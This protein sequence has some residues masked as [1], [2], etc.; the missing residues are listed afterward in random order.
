M[1]QPENSYTEFYFLEVFVGDNDALYDPYFHFCC[2]LALET[3]AKGSSIKP[4][5]DQRRLET[6]N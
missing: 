6:S 5:W 2:E 3:W 4:L 1:F